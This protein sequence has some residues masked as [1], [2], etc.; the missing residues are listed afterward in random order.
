MGSILFIGN[1]KS[2]E[3]CDPRLFVTIHFLYLQNFEQI[4]SFLTVLCLR[5]GM[6][7]YF[8]SKTKLVIYACMILHFECQ[9]K[10]ACLYTIIF[11]VVQKSVCMYVLVSVCVC[12]RVC[13]CVCVCV[14]V[15]VCMCFQSYNKAGSKTSTLP[16][17]PKNNL[18]NFCSIFFFIIISFVWWKKLNEYIIRIQ[19]KRWL[20]NFDFN[21]HIQWRGKR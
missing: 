9:K 1:M 15:C 5:P 19:M 12:V 11:T 10:I 18:S 3:R 17:S 16:H 6:K 4:A 14:C 7:K 13:L 8:P 21:K 2:V 20:Q